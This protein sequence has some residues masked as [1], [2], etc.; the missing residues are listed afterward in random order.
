MEVQ[1]F[2]HIFIFLCWNSFQIQI[3]LKLESGVIV[4]LHPTQVI[5]IPE[6][7]Y[8]IVYELKN[9]VIKTTLHCFH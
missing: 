2:C 9:V 4:Q 5:N 1:F 7:M 3:I 8:R 6:Y